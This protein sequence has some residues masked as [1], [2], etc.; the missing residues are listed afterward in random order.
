MISGCI[1]DSTGKLL[2][3]LDNDYAKEMLKNKTYQ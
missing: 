1:G 2:A 3:I